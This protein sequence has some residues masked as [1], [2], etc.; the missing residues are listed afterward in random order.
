MDTFQVIKEQLARMFGNRAQSVTRDTVISQVVDS[1][2][3]L[4]LL[5]NTEKVL[6]V[7]VSDEDFYERAPATLGELADL[8]TEL[9]VISCE[10]LSEV[11]Q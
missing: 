2:S 9:T 4:T 11:L 3:F 7:T 6:Q 8:L 1:R 10:Q 5:L